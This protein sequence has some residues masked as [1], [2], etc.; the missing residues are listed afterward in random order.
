[1]ERAESMDHCFWDQLKRNAIIVQER[2]VF[3]RT[4]MWKTKESALCQNVIPSTNFRKLALSLRREPSHHIPW[5]AWLKSLLHA[6]QAA[7]DR[8]ICTKR[9]PWALN[10]NQM[11]RT[12]VQGYQLLKILVLPKGA[13]PRDSPLLLFGACSS[14]GLRINLSSLL[15]LSSMSQSLTSQRKT[16][17]KCLNV[18]S[19]VQRNS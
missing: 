8:R 1:M 14:Y 11:W 15:F 4:M 6:H 9:D 18:K 5:Q 13:A 10:Q 12:W 7:Q 16:V 2:V 17:V 3:I 19:K